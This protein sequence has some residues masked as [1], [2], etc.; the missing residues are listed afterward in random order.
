MQ[1]AG[2]TASDWQPVATDVTTPDFT[3]NELSPRK[4]YNFRI[5]AE[6]ENGDISEPTPPIQY[7]RS[8]CK[9]RRVEK[10]EKIS[11]LKEGLYQ[12]Q[13]NALI[14]DVNTL[15]SCDTLYSCITEMTSE[16]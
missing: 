13:C 2:P 16:G 12:C 15:Y 11:C 10:C 8:Q 6:M 3:V 5:R 9:C 4:D 7:Y 1:E 14:S